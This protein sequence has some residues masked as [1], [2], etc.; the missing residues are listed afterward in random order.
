MPREMLSIEIDAPCGA[1]FNVLHDYGCRLEWDSMLREARLLAGATAA[2]LGVRSLCVGTWRSAFLAIETEYIRFKLGRVAAVK[3][4][5]HPWF[6][7]SL[8]QRY[9][10][11]PSVR[12]GRVLRTSISS[13]HSLDLLLLS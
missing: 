8:P 4:T 7:E 13:A 10:T 12:L 6:F 2:G 11:T 9:D 5:N 3:L 1:V